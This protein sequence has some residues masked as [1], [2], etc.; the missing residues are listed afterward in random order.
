MHVEKVQLP[1][2]VTE[3]ATRATLDSTLQECEQIFMG[4]KMRVAK[5]E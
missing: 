2:V 5:S 3:K 1:S 4:K